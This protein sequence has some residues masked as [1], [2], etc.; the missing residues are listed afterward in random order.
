MCVS[1]IFVQIL[2]V[3]FY[4][5]LPDFKNPNLEPTTYNITP[6]EST[7]MIKET[8]HKFYRSISDSE[9]D[10]ESQNIVGENENEDDFSKI[11]FVQKTHELTLSKRLFNEY[12]REEVIAVLC[13]TFCVF[14][15]LT[16]FNVIEILRNSLFANI[17]K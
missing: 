5:N 2:V 12:I 9:I 15:M 4:K 14:V 6:N 11:N 16:T 13:S 8:P 7:P 3:F 17:L 10:L 1:W